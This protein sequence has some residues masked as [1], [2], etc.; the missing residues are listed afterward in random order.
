MIV[1]RT[2]PRFGRL[3]F[4]QPGWTK[5]DLVR[6]CLKSLL[7]SLEG[8]NFKFHVVLDGCPSEYR[9][10]FEELIDASRLKVTDLPGGGQAASVAEGIRIIEQESESDVVYFAED[11]Y[12]Y[13]DSAMTEMLEMIRDEDAD[14]VTPYDHPDYYQRTL[15]PTK[16]A[17]LVR[18][19]DYRSEII[20][21]RRHWRTVSSTTMTFLTKKVVLK[22][23]AKYIKLTSTTRLVDYPMWLTLTKMR[24]RTVR[25][26]GTLYLYALAWPRMIVGRSFKL[27]SP[28]PSLATHMVGPYMAPGFEW[29]DLIR[30]YAAKSA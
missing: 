25:I 7:K 28:M 21:K 18:L 26:R 10:L 29:E 6:V 23:A 11:D 1:Y 16:P 13:K 3:A 5:Y 14:F 4:V 19:H 17:Y 2:Y 27:W 8:I 24:K 15:D 22:K 9:D 12:L 20:F 30:K